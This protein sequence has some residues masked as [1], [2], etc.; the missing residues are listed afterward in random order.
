MG[1]GLRSSRRRYLLICPMVFKSPAL[2]LP[3]ARNRPL[4]IRTAVSLKESVRHLHY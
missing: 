3:N 2:Y 4:P 1:C